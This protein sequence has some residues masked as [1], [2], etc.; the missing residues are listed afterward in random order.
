MGFGGLTRKISTDKVSSNKMARRKA[1]GLK[2][3][4]C[5]EAI[6]AGGVG[7]LAIMAVGTPK[8]RRVRGPR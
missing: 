3:P 1:I 7:A 8:A 2:V 4:L 5:S 6:H